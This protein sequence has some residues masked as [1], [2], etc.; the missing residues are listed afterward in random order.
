MCAHR[1]KG[2][3][4]NSHTLSLRYVN[5]RNGWRFTDGVV[6]VL[7][8]R[9]TGKSTGLAMICIAYMFVISGFRGAVAS[10]TLEQAKII[11][12]TVQQL[13]K[14]HPWFKQHGFRVGQMRATYVSIIGPDDTERSIEGITFFSPLSAFLFTNL[15][16]FF[17]KNS[18]VR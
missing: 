11:V 5:D 13:V 9:K 8:G 2:G 14:R 15:G 1:K 4:E 10:R 18:K 12:K 16:G 6:G 3:Q 7:T 17:H